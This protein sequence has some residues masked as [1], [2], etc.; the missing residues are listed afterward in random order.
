MS[1]KKTFEF[2]KGLQE[3]WET[4]AEKNGNSNLSC[5]EIREVLSVFGYFARFVS[6][7]SA[8]ATP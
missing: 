7:S 5:E 3:A 4:V 2:K 6:V 1:A 8:E